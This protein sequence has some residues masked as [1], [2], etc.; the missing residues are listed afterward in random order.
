MS[1]VEQAVTTVATHE[2]VLQL[3]TDRQVHAFD[4]GDTF[5]VALG[6]HHS[7]EVQLRSRRVS[8]Y[9][10]EILSEVDGL[11]VHDLGSTNGTYVNDEL[12][13][14]QQLKTGDRIR[15][16]GFNITVRLV[17]RSVAAESA[18][19]EKDLLV[20]GTVGNLLPFRD[21]AATAGAG[22]EGA[23]TDT[24]LPAL[25]T[26]LGRRRASIV[27]WIRN[28]S[29]EGK[30]YVTDGSV[31]H[32]ELGGQ[33][34]EKAL[35]R[36]LALQKGTYELHTLPPAGVPQTIQ[37]PTE[38]LV[39]EGMQQLEAL[40]GLTSKLPPLMYE[41]ALN[42][43]CTIPVSALTSDELEIYQFLI[44]YQ[45]LVRVLEESPM[46]DFMVLVLTHGLLQKG[47]FQAT[48]SAGALLEETSFARQQ[49]G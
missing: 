21:R 30:I 20:A 3:A 42:E 27:V 22:P 36:L 46:T 28:P 34:K 40:E 24:T 11:F 1:A 6:R 15:I 7:N 37:V 9:H 33:R 49:T 12:V 25:L 17:P 8:N 10:A 29:E 19:G 2:M 5:R 26:E 4:L 41:I 32:C 23:D 13:R 16:G 35:Y 48:R 43:G 14:R 38:S 47:F 39:I 31:V 45:S 18:G 44:R